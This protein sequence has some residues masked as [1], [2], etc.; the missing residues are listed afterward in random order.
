M[1][2]QQRLETW[3]LRLETLKAVTLVELPEVTRNLRLRSGQE[4]FTLIELLVVI[5]IIAILLALLAPALD[6]AVYQAELAVCGT[7]Q[8]QAARAYVAYTQSNRRLFP[9]RPTNESKVL[10]TGT[11]GLRRRPH[12]IK[13]S[14]AA[15]ANA[16]TV[17][18]QA[19]GARGSADGS[20]AM[21]ADDRPYLR[22]AGSLKLLLD[23][24]CPRIDLEIAGTDTIVAG[25][26]GLWF[27]FSYPAASGGGRGIFRIGDELEWTDNWRGPAARQNFRVLLSDWDMPMPM[28]ETNANAAQKVITSHPDGQNLLYTQRNQDSGGFT[29]SWWTSGLATGTSHRPPLDLNFAMTD[30]SV[31]RI[32]AVEWDD[33]RMA[34]MPYSAWIENWSPGNEA[35]SGWNHL[36]RR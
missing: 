12:I 31:Q 6:K 10:A 3:D 9:Y 11:Q 33:P 20:L 15:N 34:R 16:F 7:T 27:G 19:P 4:G 18:A 36:P 35:A 14:L 17:F 30:G 2:L 24:L 23:P 32:N 29:I 21:W 1:K 28:F 13:D 25:N 5:T 8:G 26:F 22:A